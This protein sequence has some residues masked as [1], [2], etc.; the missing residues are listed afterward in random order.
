LRHCT[1]ISF[2]HVLRHRGRRYGKTGESEKSERWQQSKAET[3]E[4]GRKKKEEKK[5][6]MRDSPHSMNVPWT[7]GAGILQLR[8]VPSVAVPIHLFDLNQPACRYIHPRPPPSILL[9]LKQGDEKKNGI[10]KKRRRRKKPTKSRQLTY[11]TSGRLNPMD[12]KSGRNKDTASPHV[13]LAHQY[14]TRSGLR[15]TVATLSH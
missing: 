10:K 9:P 1:V 4:E 6:E 8:L 2:Y 11:Q 14:I 7:N 12:D 3:S 13:P 15:T 5:K